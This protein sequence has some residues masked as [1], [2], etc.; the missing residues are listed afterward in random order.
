MDEKQ[1]RQEKIYDLRARPKSAPPVSAG[2]PV[3]DVAAFLEQ[4]AE[5]LT[6]WA[7]HVGI[8][9]HYYDPRIEEGGSNDWGQALRD[10]TERKLVNPVLSSLVARGR[11]DLA[12]DLQG[13]FDALFADAQGYQDRLEAL[14]DH[15][16]VHVEG[17]TARYRQSFRDDEHAARLWALCRG[18]ERT[19]TIWCEDCNPLDTPEQFA[20]AVDE[21]MRDELWGKQKARSEIQRR[22][23]DLAEHLN[24]IAASVATETPSPAK[25]TKKPKRR[26]RW[27]VARTQ[28]EVARYLSE[29]RAKYDKLVPLCLQGDK[30][31]H[32]EFKKFFGSEAVARALGDDCYGQAV[33]NT[34][35]YKKLLQPVIQNRP[36]EGWQPAQQDDGAF[37]DDIANM[38][39][40]A[41]N[42]E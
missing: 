20:E 26:G 1:R 42:D 34:E 16:R 36:P 2:Q 29:R 11:A 23:H 3:P 37:A 7:D 33:Q 40:Q 21:A 41:M 13:R 19:F 6:G 25:E 5:E 28:P 22:A 31:A 8:E 30:K 15:R 35:T 10:A 24:I 27:P 14:E 4:L 38:R 39:R 9:A 17:L 12:G 18:P 32:K